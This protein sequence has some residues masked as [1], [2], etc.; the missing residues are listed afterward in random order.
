MGSFELNNF[1][2]LINFQD[3]LVKVQN[4][5]KFNFNDSNGG[6]PGPTIQVRGTANKPVTA[7][8]AIQDDNSLLSKLKSNNETFQIQVQIVY[9]DPQRIFQY[10]L[11][12]CVIV[13]K[14]LEFESPDR[15]Q[16]VYTIQ[17]VRVRDVLQ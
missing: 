12:E 3:R 13:R 17:S 15:V 11:D 14:E 4:V 1:D 8:I 9:S 16:S 2:V 5:I 10:S 6:S 7:T